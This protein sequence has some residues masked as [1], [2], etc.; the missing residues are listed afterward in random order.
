[1]R[2]IPAATPRPS[3]SPRSASAALAS[4]TTMPK[5]AS[6]GCAGFFAVLRSGVRYSA[7]PTLST[8]WRTA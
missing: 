7:L 3:R 6:F 2:A 1:M 5:R 8:A 4:G